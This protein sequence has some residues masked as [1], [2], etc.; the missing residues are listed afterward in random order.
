MFIV[1]EI[2]KPE[3]HYHD[4]IKELIEENIFQEQ[5]CLIKYKS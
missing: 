1:L 4:T 5:D 3:V 2:I